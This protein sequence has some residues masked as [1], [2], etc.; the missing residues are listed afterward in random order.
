MTMTAATT[1]SSDPWALA[2]QA[3]NP[4]PNPYSTRP[5]AWVA[6]SLGEHLWTRQA[7]IAAALVDHRH[8][9]VH[10]CHGA[11]KSYLASRLIAWW[12][13]THRPHAAFV[14]S[15]APT[16]AQVRAILWREIGRAHRKGRLPGRVN[17]TEWHIGDELVGYGRKPADHDEH[18]FQGIHAEAVLVVIDEA[19][20]V[21]EQL[22][23]AADALVTNDASRVLAIGNPDDPTSHFARVCQPGSGWHVVHIDGL[24]TPNFTGEQVPADL[25]P[26]LLSDT[27]VQERK[28]RWGET[29][30]LY[31]SKVRGLFP[32]DAQ[33]GVIPY[34]WIARC[35]PDP[36]PDLDD[37]CEVQL[38]VDV[39]AGGDQTVIWERRG[40]RLG[41]VWRSNS[42]DPA[43]VVDIAERAVGQSDATIVCVDAIGV[44]WGIAGWLEDR[45]P[46]LQVHKVNVGQAS[47]EPGRFL[48]LRAELWWTV[49]REGIE[50]GAYDLTDLDDDSAAQLCAPKYFENARGAI[51][52]ESKDDL[53][54]RI[55][56]SPDDA[57]ALLL[58][59]YRPTAGPAEY[60]PSIYT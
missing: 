48:N 30:P 55:G 34:S 3:F 54:A 37:S 59:F 20:G 11:G 27:W 26:L 46:D 58:A 15:T 2:A 24:D 47:S 12:L 4:A 42:A 35:K 19:C 29:S 22:W 16:F 51:Q 18:A 60:L 28:Q 23:T 57:D 49:G 50:A 33:D 13:D 17:Q 14:V 52:I 45:C 9:A 40:Q 41:R 39:G 44:G 56:R 6:D 38:G 25:R 32:D 31:T 53:R 5:A 8:V 21:P 36:R 1:A 7:D 43:D 10:S